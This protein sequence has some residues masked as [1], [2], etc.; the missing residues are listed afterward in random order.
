MTSLGD[1]AGVAQPFSFAFG[2]S[3]DGS[4]IAGRGDGEDGGRAVIWR[5][6][7]AIRNLQ[8]LLE[9]DFGLKD[10]AGWTLVE[11]RGVSTF[12]TTIVGWGIHNGIE[13]AW[14]AILPE[15]CP[16]DLDHD[17]IVGVVDMLAL[18]SG[19]GPC[20]NCMSCP[21]DLNSDWEGVT[22]DL[23]ISFAVGGSGS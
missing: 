23:S 19:F 9:V 2:V 10:M 17:G 1:L 18:L 15:Q 16:A 20:S 3:A 7:S 8:E 22:P 5:S 13:E 11:A 6:G 21:A 4:T 12:G 14:M